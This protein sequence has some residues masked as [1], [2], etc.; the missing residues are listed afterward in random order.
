MVAGDSSLGSAVPGELISGFPP[1][2]AST[3][4]TSATLSAL[5][6]CKELSTVGSDGASTRSSPST[7]PSG[8]GESSVKG[9]DCRDSW[10]LLGPA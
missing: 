4:L 3:S 1:G 2:E 5:D 6:S 8:M 9:V 7:M 10:P